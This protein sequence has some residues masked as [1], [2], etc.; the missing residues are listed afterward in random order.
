MAVQRDL[1]VL[2]TTDMR[3]HYYYYYYYYHFIF[4][5]IIIIITGAPNNG[6]AGVRGMGDVP[7]GGG[8][9]CAMQRGGEPEASGIV[10]ASGMIAR[11]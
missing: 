7:G 3:E 4:I 1:E 2:Q 5:I 8:A 10:Q 6:G 9:S 11:R